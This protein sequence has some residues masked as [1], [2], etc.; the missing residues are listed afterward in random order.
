MAFPMMGKLAKKKPADDNDNS[1]EEM[2]EK[3]A[4]GK[5]FA[6]FEKNEDKGGY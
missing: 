1:A 5:K 6:A 4:K 2:A 3:K